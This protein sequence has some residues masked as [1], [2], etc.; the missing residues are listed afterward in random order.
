MFFLVGWGGG[1][2]G[3]VGVGM[4]SGE[5]DV[6]WGGGDLVD[7]GRGHLDGV[8]VGWVAGVSLWGSDW[9]RW[10]MCKC[11][12]LLATIVTVRL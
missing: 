10:V 9:V 7:W 11:H 8:G 5:L 12:N 4:W 3:W 6:W 1:L 2:A